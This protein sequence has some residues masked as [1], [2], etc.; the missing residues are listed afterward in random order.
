MRCVLDDQ[1]LG[2][3]SKLLSSGVVHLLGDLWRTGRLLRDTA[4]MPEGKR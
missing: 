2:G 3:I 1:Q 4:Y